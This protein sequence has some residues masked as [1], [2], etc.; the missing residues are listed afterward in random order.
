[1]A[2]KK[3]RNKGGTRYVGRTFGLNTS[4]DY[5]NRSVATPNYEFYELEPAEVIDIILND[6]HPDFRSYSDIGKAKI[7]FINSETGKDEGILSYA[8]PLDSGVKNFPL[9]HEVVIG[10][11]Y[12]GD[13]YYTQRLNIFN[14]P[15]ENSFPFISSLAFQNKQN[16]KGNAQEY[17]DV[18][19][20]GNPNIAGGNEEIS[21]GN[22]F[23]RN[24]LV[25]PL[26]PFEGD[27]IIEGRFGETIRL[28]SNQETGFPTMKITVGQQEEIPDNVIQPIEEDFNLDQNSIWIG[29]DE[30]IPLNPSTLE[31]DVHLQ[32]YPDKPSEFIGNQ[33]FMN[34]DRIVFNTKQNEFMTFAKKA[35]NFVTQ[36]IF[37]VD[38]ES[39]IILNSPKTTIVNSPEIYLGSADATEPIVLGDSWE[40]LMGELIDALLAMT[41]PTP[42]G[43]SGTPLNAADFTTI[44]NKLNSVLSKQNFSL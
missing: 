14:N 38:A 15:N 26:Q 21:L 18:S 42:A 25:R 4:N 34:S 39:D 30:D 12:V 11:R 43:P 8:K 19:T 5:S 40:T 41:H 24:D 3:D 22:T 9:L 37:T 35:I 27:Y 31:S 32:F 10:V 7:R 2:F 36:G 23:K 16:T 17:E 28:G 13:L 33:I 44:K 29:T 20:S 6:Q 1:M